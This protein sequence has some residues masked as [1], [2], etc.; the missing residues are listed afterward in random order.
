MDEKS[1]KRIHIKERL[2]EQVT[3]PTIQKNN[4]TILKDA[5]IVEDLNL[6]ISLR[7]VNVDQHIHTVG[8]LNKAKLVCS[9]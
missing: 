9:Y 2:G 1:S 4:Y 3:I 7:Y 5:L 6:L 8:L